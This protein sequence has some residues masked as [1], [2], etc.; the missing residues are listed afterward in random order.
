MKKVLLTLLMCISALAVSYAQLS[1]LT[2]VEFY[3]AYLDVPIV[4]TASLA[5]GKISNA[6]L[7]YIFKKTNPDDVKYAIINALGAKGKADKIRT[8]NRKIFDDYMVAN[9]EEINDETF[10]IF[11]R[12]TQLCILYFYAVTNYRDCDDGILRGAQDFS[13]SCNRSDAVISSLICAQNDMNPFIIERDDYLESGER[14]TV[15]EAEEFNKKWEKPATEIARSVKYACFAK[16]CDEADPFHNDMREKAVNMVWEYFKEYDYEIEESKIII[17]N[18]SSNPYEISINGDVIGNLGGGRTYE[19]EVEP[20]YYHIKAVQVS[21][22]MFS[23]TVNNR[24]VNLE[25]G[26]SKTVYVGFED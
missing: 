12:G 18:K 11:S 16:N 10:R 20:G 17:V 5:N 26:D 13:A 19:K 25:D 9:Y 21:G 23:P 24:D 8:V 14:M 6:M 2:E 15:L 1:P 3:K 4:R 7:D 22:Y